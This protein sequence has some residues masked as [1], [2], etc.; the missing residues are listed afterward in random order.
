HVVTIRD[1]RSGQSR[2]VVRRD[3]SEL[4]PLWRHRYEPG[5]R[6][7]KALMA[8]KRDLTLTVDVRLQAA[9]ARLLKQRLAAAG[10]QSGAVVAL[11]AESGELL[12]S[13]SAPWPAQPLRGE[14]RPGADEG[15]G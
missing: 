6:S 11:D 3:R 4:I 10:A 12:A 15:G 5:H 7:V 13:V 9:A 2:R 14:E 1:P 8:R